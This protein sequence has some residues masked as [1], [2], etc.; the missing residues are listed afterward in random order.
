MA[1]GR[2]NLIHHHGP[3]KTDGST[4]RDIRSSI[5]PGALFGPV[6]GV[7]VPNFVAPDHVLVGAVMVGVLSAVTATGILLATMVL[8]VSV[9]DPRFALALDVP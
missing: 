6:V 5:V 1:L 9:P 3:Y 7:G 4:G 2:V 8:T